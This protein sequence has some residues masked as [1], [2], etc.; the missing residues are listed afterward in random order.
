LAGVLPVS[1]VAEQ[2]LPFVVLDFF[3][4]GMDGNGLASSLTEAVG[5]TSGRPTERFQGG[6]P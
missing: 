1:A 5:K 6:E 3:D 2:Y 4:P